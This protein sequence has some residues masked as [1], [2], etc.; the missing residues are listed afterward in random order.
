MI[1]QSCGF[2]L[3]VHKSVSGLITTP[4]MIPLANAECT[5]L[6][7]TTTDENDCSSFKIYLYQRENTVCYA[8][9]V[10]LSLYKNN[11]ISQ[12]LNLLSPLLLWLPFQSKFPILNSI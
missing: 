12:A 8:H 2:S 10:D 9:A 3:G 1:T 5:F 11:L 4:E 6:D 7:Q